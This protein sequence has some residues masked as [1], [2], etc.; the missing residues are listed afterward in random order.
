MTKVEKIANLVSEL[1][2]DEF[3]DFEQGIRE[4]VDG[5]L[6]DV[7]QENSDA[8]SHAWLWSIYRWMQKNKTKARR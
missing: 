1:T 2:F 5:G 6:A 4:E 7:D 8:V 3:T